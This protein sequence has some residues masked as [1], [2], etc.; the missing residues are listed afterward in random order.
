MQTIWFAWTMWIVDANC[1]MNCY[2]SIYFGHFSGNFLELDFV[3]FLSNFQW[4]FVMIPVQIITHSYINSSINRY[5]IKRK[6]RLTKETFFTWPSK[7]YAFTLDANY[8]ANT[9][10]SHVITMNSS[11]RMIISWLHSFICLLLFF[12][13]LLHRH[14]SL[15]LLLYLI[16]IYHRNFLIYN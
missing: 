8:I 12:L 14:F 10:L 6:K 2:F 13:Q 1:V 7:R 9:S 3:Q 15:F 11:T 4:K 5:N 16:H